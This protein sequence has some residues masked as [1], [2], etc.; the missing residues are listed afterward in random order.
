MKSRALLFIFMFAAVG[1]ILLAR[2]RYPDATRYYD[3]SLYTLYLLMFLALVAGGGR[4]RNTEPGDVARY[5]GIWIAVIFGLVLLY[6]IF[7][8][9]L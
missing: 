4:Y 1:L 6:E 5:A 2:W 9:Y 8:R 7:K 3:E